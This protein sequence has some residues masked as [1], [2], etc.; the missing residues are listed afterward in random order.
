MLTRLL[1]LK[2]RER[3]II[4][5]MIFSVFLK[6]A[7]I[8]ISFYL[9]P[10]YMG[11]FN[12]DN[13]L[14]L[15]FT[16]LALLSWF[17]TFDLGISNGLRN[18]LVKP[19]LENDYL[20]VR[21]LIS[22][23]YAMI[24]SIVSIIS[25]LTFIVFYF[26]NWKS[27]FNSHFDNAFLYKILII[28]F[29]G[30][31]IQF[32][33][34][35]VYAVLYALQKPNFVSITAL[36]SNI[37]L[38]LGIKLLPISTEDVNLFNLS[39]VY[40]VTAIMPI[41]VI[42]WYT[43]KILLK[44]TIPSIK[45]VD[46]LMGRK[47]LSLGG[48]FFFIQVL[49]LVLSNTNEVFIT[50]TIDSKDVVVYKIYNSLFNSV[51]MF[52]MVMMTPMWSEITAAYA[53]NEFTWLK[54]LLKKLYM[55]LFCAIIGLT[56]LG[57]SSQYIIDFWLK[58]KAIEVNYMYVLVFSIYVF[59]SIWNSVVSS[60]ANGMGHLKN[61]LI[62]MA[63]GVVIFITLVLSTRQYQSWIFIVLANTIALMP[64]CVTQSLWLK[65][66]FNGK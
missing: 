34:K 1:A 12:H 2:V 30:I 4:K 48:M 11:F 24:I 43:Y 13:T 38:L 49:Y 35:I 26:I 29:S 10:T 46:F 20:K 9:I 63:I 6:G 39:L 47:I 23:A 66:Y 21:K 33:L 16:I 17:M 18:N 50:S 42:T 14:G 8:F 36:I 54:S 41:L 58:D 15:W 56:V 22:S 44:N 32:I 40:V 60:F 51:S 7:G 28:I 59:V 65:K 52:F 61:Q 55:L 57:L 3:R 19:L 64:Y 53:K 31:M 37:L 62:F 25:V 5:N 27:F 45:D